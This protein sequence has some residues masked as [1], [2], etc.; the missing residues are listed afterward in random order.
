MHPGPGSTLTSSQCTLSLPHC[1]PDA[2]SSLGSQACHAFLR[3]QGNFHFPLPRNF[4]RLT[5]SPTSGP[6]SVTHLLSSFLSPCYL[7]WIPYPPYTKHLLLY[8]VILFV[9][10]F[11]HLTNVSSS[12]K[13]EPYFQV[14]C[15]ISSAWHIVSAQ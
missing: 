1:D 12:V 8:L 9:F 7:R 10:V 4:K 6:I 3:P 11:S 15:W 2:Q 5:A 14:H 13:A